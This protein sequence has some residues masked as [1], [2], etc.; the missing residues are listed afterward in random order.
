MILALLRFPC[1]LDCPRV[2]FSLSEAMDAAEDIGVG[3]ALSRG[4][5]GDE[6]RRVLL[7]SVEAERVFS[8]AIVPASQVAQHR[9]L[10]G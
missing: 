10:V 4:R 7:T 5:V 2:R 6:E 8:R 1:R 9:C 3:E